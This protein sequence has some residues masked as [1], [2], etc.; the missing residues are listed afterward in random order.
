MFIRNT[1][2]PTNLSIGS[3]SPKHSFVPTMALQL[4]RHV[5][6]GFVLFPL[7]FP[8]DWSGPLDVFNTLRPD[9]PI[10]A[11]SDLSVSSTLLAADLYPVEMTGGW[12]VVPQQTFSEALKEEWDI[13]L[14]PG[15]RG[16]RPWDENNAPAQ[17]FIKAIAPNVKYLLTVCT[18]SWLV[19]HT[20]LLSG[21][22]ATTNKSAFNNAKEHTKDKGVTWVPKARWVV[23]EKFWTASGVS[24]GLDMASAFFRQFL[25]LHMTPEEA[26]A[27]GDKL[28]G[29][30]EI[31]ENGPEDDPWAEYYNL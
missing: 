5:K 8:L 29:V 4:P 20:G 18:G 26:K 22:R 21:R 3:R 12:S 2:H 9:S 17:E 6:V 11:S 14:V 10:A 25:A 16:A 15:G 27:T 7:A 31:I 1:S 28:L 23:D 24:A 19:A 13:I 30:L